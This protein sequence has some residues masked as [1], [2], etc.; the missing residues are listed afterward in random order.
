MPVEKV[1]GGYHIHNTATKKPLPYSKALK[2]LAAIQISKNIRAKHILE[3]M[4]YNEE[5]H[6]KL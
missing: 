1:K 2:Q 6:E 3:A 5:N 4:D